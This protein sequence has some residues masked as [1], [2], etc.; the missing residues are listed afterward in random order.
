M[1]FLYKGLQGQWEKVLVRP[2][3]LS[4]P[5]LQFQTITPSPFKGASKQSHVLGA[6]ILYINNTGA[7]KGPGHA[8]LM[9]LS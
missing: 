9:N 6:W 1:P 2:S 4:K 8:R 5:F 7:K 3:C